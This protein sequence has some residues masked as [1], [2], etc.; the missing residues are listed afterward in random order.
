MNRH[1]KLLISSICLSMLVNFSSSAND[2][3]PIQFDIIKS[4]P[5]AYINENGKEV[6]TYWEYAD[7]IAEETGISIAKSIMPKSRLISNLK[8][9]HSDAA[10]LFKT[11]SL[12][13]HVEYIVQVRTIPIIVATQKGTLINH[14]DDLK[15]LATIGVFRSGVINPRFDNDNQL[16]KDFISSYP[17]MVKMLA[18]KR[19]DAITGNGVALKALINQ[20]CLQDKVEI[21]PLLMGKRE[22]WLVMS[23]KSEHLDQAQTIKESILKLKAKGALDTIFEAH[24]S[25][26]NHTCQ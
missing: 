26:H 5:F 7:L 6:G 15:S 14:Y 10:I 19:L 1:V 22:Q 21:S 3:K 23:K 8:S 20:M 2:I 12:N 24:V 4:Y 11:D 16:N 13:S 18:A 25:Q 17:K 9:G